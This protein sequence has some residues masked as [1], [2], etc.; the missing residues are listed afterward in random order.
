MVELYDHN[1]TLDDIHN[2]QPGDVIVYG[3]KDSQR[4][5]YLIVKDV[6]VEN[7]KI[8][9]QIASRTGVN[10]VGLDNLVEE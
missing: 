4:T 8:S 9:G 10:A 6:D 1:F 7:G 2:V 3:P 5:N